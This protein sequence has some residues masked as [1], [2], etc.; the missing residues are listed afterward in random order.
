MVALCRSQPLDA[1][2]KAA[3]VNGK[4]TR[5]KEIRIVRNSYQKYWN[6]HPYRLAATSHT[7]MV[8]Q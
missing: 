4:G 1:M 8:L 6:G 5:R 7:R 3:G 2:A